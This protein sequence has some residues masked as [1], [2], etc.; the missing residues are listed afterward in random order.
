M[1]CPKE[2]PELFPILGQAVESTDDV[3]QHRALLTL[4]HVVKAISSKRL[5]GD[6]KVFQDF[7]LNIYSYILNLWDTFTQAFINETAQ[8]GPVDAITI[9]LEKALLTLRIIR[10]LTMFGFTTPHENQDCV[11]FMN[12]I[13]EKAKVVLQCRKQLTE[14]G[15]NVLELSEKFVIHLTKTLSSVLDMYPYSFIDFIRPTLEFTFFF[16]F[17]DDGLPYTFERF[18]IQCFNLIKNILVTAEY[19]RTAPFAVAAYETKQNFFQAQITSDICRKL[20]GHYFLLTQDEL[21]MWDSDPESFV[22]DQSGDSWKYSLRVKIRICSF[23]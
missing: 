3:V 12:V 10:R 13:F 20:I 9:Q 2:W 18:V 23:I 14:K 5:P 22:I 8:G 6:R 15:I 17:T 7:A 16:L 11:R 4:H 1:D 19:R 21:E